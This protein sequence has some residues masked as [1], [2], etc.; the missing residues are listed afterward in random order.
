[1]ID[2]IEPPK[3]PNQVN[4]WNWL[5]PFDYQ[6]WLLIVA[7][8]IIS[9]LVFMAIEFL[10]DE[11]EGRS[12]WQ[13]F[14]DNMY[15]SGL[16]FTQNFEYAPTSFPGRVFGISMSIWALVI[17]ATYTANLASLLVEQAKPPLKVDS[18]EHAISLNMPICAWQD[19]MSAQ[20]V[21]KKKGRIVP[22]K[23]DR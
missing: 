8:I 4:L 2:M 13:W 1:L 11:R 15:L 12:F 3:D 7:T 14:S 21:E 19:T 17:T 5:R 20:I 16:N 22:K 18:I 23:N 10:T 9:G 6:V